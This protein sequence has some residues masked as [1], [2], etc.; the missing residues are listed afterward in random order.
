MAWGKEPGKSRRQAPPQGCPCPQARV[1]ETGRDARVWETDGRPSPGGT[2][3]PASLAAPPPFPAGWEARVARRTTP[4][5][6]PRG[7][8]AARGTPE[9][10]RLGRSHGRL[11]L[12][13]PSL[14]PA[15]APSPAPRR[16]GGAI[17]SDA[18]AAQPALETAPLVANESRE[19]AAPG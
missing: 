16:V 15:G 7:D 11:H 19:G 6:V 1:L 5:G 9:A 10:Q 12:L 17:P 18:S 14:P 2:S 3:A 13:P 4:P 8:A